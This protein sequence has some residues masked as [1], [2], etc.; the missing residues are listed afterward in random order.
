M[1]AW[2]EP[3]PE[4]CVMCKASMI[5]DMCAKRQHD[6]KAC[7]KLQNGK[8]HPNPDYH[9]TANVCGHGGIQICKNADQEVHC[10]AGF[11]I[12][13]ADN[14]ISLRPHHVLAGQD[15]H[16]PGN[17][18]LLFDKIIPKQC[19]PAKLELHPPLV[20]SALSTV[21]AAEGNQGA[22]QMPAI[23][24]NLRLHAVNYEV[25]SSCVVL[26]GLELVASSRNLHAG[27]DMLKANAGRDKS[28]HASD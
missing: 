6:F 25:S 20:Q 11:C 8:K 15:S 24:T 18:M 1:V 19:L 26:Q 9:S 2:L 17:S 13:C 12:A 3:V 10:I 28:F 21:H 14:C 7:R 27:P 22:G 4:C 16:N 23:L 5:R